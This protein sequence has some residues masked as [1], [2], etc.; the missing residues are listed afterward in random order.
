MPA[1]GW[2]AL[3]A[4]GLGFAFTGCSG[5]APG[6]ADNRGPFKLLLA[7]TGLGQIY[8]Y[9]IIEV[10]EKQSPTQKVI[11]ILEMKHLRDNVTS[12]NGVLPVTTFGVDARLPGGNPG[13]QFLLMAFSH[14]LKPESILSDLPANQANSGLTGSIQVL[15]YDPTNE[16]QQTVRGRGFVGGYTYYDDPATPNLDLKLVK[17]VEADNGGN[18]VIRDPRANGFPAG[19][20]G[21]AD[22][23]A[24]GAFVF[25]PD[26]DDNLTTFET[27]PADRVFRI[28]AGA[29]VQDYR[30][31]P[32]VEEVTVATVQGTD[33]IAPQVIG[34]ST[35]QPQI[36]PG[37]GQLGVDP[38]TTIHVAFSKPVQ[39]HDVGQFFTSN[40]TPPFR[41]VQIKV[42]VASVTVPVIYYADPRS[43]SDLCNYVVKPG[44]YFLGNQPVTVI[45]N[46]TI[47]GLT[48]RALGQQV[49]TG[50]TTGIGPGL[51]NVP[52]A[53]EAIYVGRGGS[54][55]GVSVI[56]LNGFGQ[57]TGDLA[58]SQD[59]NYKQG[60]KRNPNL[61][62]PGLIPNLSLGSSNMDAGSLGALTL[63]VDSRG[64]SEPLASLLIGKSVLSQVGD[65]D[66]GQPLDK[67]YNNENINPNYTRANQTNPLTGATALSWGNPITVAPHPNPPRLFFPP[68]NPARA[69][70]GEDP[71]MSTWPAP[72]TSVPPCQSSPRNRLSTGN[73]FSPTD[74]GIGIFH[75]PIPGQ[76]WG[77]QPVPGNPQPPIF[78]CPYYSRQQI[79]HFLYV[80]DRERKQI[81]VINSNRFTVLET[82][83][84]ADPFA[85]AVSPNLKRLA[86]TNFSAGSVVAIDIDPGSPRFHQ[87]LGE[88]KVGRGPTALS[89][90]PEG[91]DLLVVNS[92]S[93]NM[94]IL[95]GSDL[96]LRKTVSGLIN[97]PL[98]VVVTHRQAGVVGFQTGIYF[99][100]ILNGNG[101]VAIFESGPDGVNGIGFDDVVGI[102]ATAT[103]RG[104]R[105]MM[106]DIASLNSAVWVAHLDETNL[107]QV[108]HLELTSSTV[109]A[110][111]ISPNSGGFILPPTFRQ[112]DWTITGRLGGAAPTTPVKDRFSGNSVIDLALDEMNNLGTFPEPQSTQISNLVYA[113]HSAKSQL[114]ILPNNQVVP[115]VTS[116]FLFIALSDVGKVDVVEV[117]TGQVVRSIDVPGVR[118]V[119]SYWK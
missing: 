30:D 44:Y 11:D 14:R 64:A 114:R 57:G 94:S 74:G 18:I 7:T 116:R 93:S 102:P 66:V 13:N 103:F 100:Y 65:I 81:L 25:I 47:R 58:K 35:T 8:P 118:V 2:A 115:A 12:T 19:F 104:A 96:S 1:A 63:C 52:V 73:P 109:G 40:L 28:I 95:R 17:A 79:G 38:G 119:S 9:R 15:E 60:F 27:Y 56:D 92:L 61:G 39:P 90:Q 88:T 105:R 106:N 33:N 6:S 101:S 24:P 36:S 54:E 31:K 50:F 75:S 113:D 89:W 48:G 59:P 41:G 10:D 43:P 98:D 91:E 42:A 3:G 72:V 71:T 23:V 82:I 53:P 78:Y 107:G 70:Y 77:P 86:V 62:Q 51:V 21:A 111:P 84:V 69:I 46:T 49:T 112:R 32:L 20:N 85:M 4:I 83:K 5:G 80:L 97:N 87:I 99:A 37:N 76:F 67:V 117:G 22:L 16:I 29:S 108:S 110:L 55:P 34:Y 26:V 68:P 45:V